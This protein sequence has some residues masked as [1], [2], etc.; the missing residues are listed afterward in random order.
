MNPST[1]T[2]SSHADNSSTLEA[3]KNLGDLLSASAARNPQKAAIDFEHRS[4]SYESLEQATTRLA[5]WF[6]QQ[7]C[8]P[9]DRI[10]FYW[11]NSIEAAELYFACFKARLIAVPVNVLMK[12]HELAYVL[13]HSKAVMCF[14]RPDLAHVA[15][16]AGRSCAPLRAIHTSVESLNEGELESQLPEVS[17][18]DPALIIYT[19]G[20][21]ALPKGVTHTHRTLLAN[22]TIGLNSIPDLERCLVMTQLAF[23]SGIYYGLLTVIASC[24]TIV[25]APAFEA[26]HVLDLI[27]RFQCTCTFGLPSMLQLLLEE[28]ALRPRQVRSI[29]TFFAAGDAVPIST[30]ERF[31]E[32]F[33]IA[34]RECLG[35]T[36]TGLTISNPAGAI[37]PGS[38]G[39]PVDGVEVKVVDSKGEEMP[40]GQTGELIVKTPGNLVRYWE[41]PIATREALRDG[42]L[43]TG[44]LVRRDSDGYFWFE[45]RKKQII[46][47]DGFNISPQEVEEAIYSHSAVLEVGVIGMPDS[48]EARGERVVAFVALRDGCVTSEEELREH[49][50]RRLADLKVP[51]KIVFLKKLPK[52]ISGKIQRSALKQSQLA[53]A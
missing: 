32:Q 47:R 44:D 26:P 13:E 11:P 8:K 3:I 34:L 28:Q 36:E 17:L 7:G 19:S 50:R 27:E 31:Q 37:R 2:N 48:V 29:R 4:I 16:E 38:L 24:G 35:M 53:A 30:H 46:V 40:D 22:V 25:L 45:G 33:G 1:H 23:M 43:V 6:L 15:M 51:E 39:I 18:S 5:R 52:G 9:G 12:A 20:T 21:T 41:D 14:A 49:A 10:A 42:W